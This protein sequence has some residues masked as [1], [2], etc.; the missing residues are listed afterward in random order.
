MS[1]ETSFDL[2]AR[3][4]TSVLER[5]KGAGRLRVTA[6][7]GMVIG[8]GRLVAGPATAVLPAEP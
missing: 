2:F 1:A 5:R 3:P 4:T 7:L 6:G 8:D